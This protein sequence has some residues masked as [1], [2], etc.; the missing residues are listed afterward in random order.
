MLVLSV[1]SLKGICWSARTID[2]QM[3]LAAVVTFEYCLAFAVYMF[4]V[5][6][7]AYRWVIWASNGIV[8]KAPGYP[9]LT[10]YASHCFHV[11]SESFCI[12]NNLHRDIA[13]RFIRTFFL[14]M[15][16]LTTS[17]THVVVFDIC[18]KIIMG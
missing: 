2:T 18:H 12:G 15:S 10:S 3:V 17:S 13:E 7:G 8:V 6:S 11:G 9:S 1:H 14:P 4:T 16:F 5:A